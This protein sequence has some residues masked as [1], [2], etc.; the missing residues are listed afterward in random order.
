MKK[1]SFLHWGVER[2]ECGLSVSA[3]CLRETGWRRT[4]PELESSKRCFFRFG[5]FKTKETIFTSMLSMGG[6]AQRTKASPSDTSMV[7]SLTWLE[8]AHHT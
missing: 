7:S 2:M 8:G 3:C 6:G 5:K 1:Q 4:M